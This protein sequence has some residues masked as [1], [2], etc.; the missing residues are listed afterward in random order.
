MP[1]GAPPAPG[2]PGA[3]R[4]PAAPTAIPQPAEPEPAPAAAAA[5][6][7][8]AEVPPPPPRQP[9]GFLDAGAIRAAAEGQGLRLPS[10]AYAS[11]AAALASGRHVLL[12]GPAGSG[13]TTLALAVARAAVTSG[14]AG[15][16]MMYT[17]TGHWSSGDALGRPASDGRPATTGTVPDA[18]TRGRWLVIDE[19]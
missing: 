5:P 7:R 11:L 2:P 8:L 1:P 19:L 18:A 6:P 14:R 17:P 9:S 4:P 10:S 13:K 16:A 3:P 12:T 15:G